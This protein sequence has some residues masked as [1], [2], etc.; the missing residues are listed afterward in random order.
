MSDTVCTISPNT[1]SPSSL[2]TV[3]FQILDKTFNIYF[4]SDDNTL[5]SGNTET[6]IACALLPSMKMG[7][8]EIRI[9]GEISSKFLSALDTIQDIYCTWQPSFKR[10]KITGITAL[11][12]TQTAQQKRVGAF[13][14][15]GVDSLY[16]F[17]KHN[18]EI[19]D[20]IFAYGLD[21]K[22]KDTVMREQTSKKIHA[23]ASEFGKNVIEIE[24]NLLELFD[25]YVNW[26]QLGHGA[27][28]AA[29]GHLFSCT[30]HR[31]Y[32]PSSY[33]YSNLFPWGS[34]PI[35]D[36]L[37]S[38]ENLEFI[39]D[40]CEA[41]RVN[42]VAL[43]AQYDIALNTL[44]VCWTNPDSVYNCGK[45]EKCIRTMINLKINNALSRCTTFSE[46][47][48]IKQVKKIVANTVGTRAFIQENL[49][50]LEKN[51]GDEK[52]R[53][54]LIYVLNKPEIPHLKRFRRK[55][56]NHIKEIWKR[57]F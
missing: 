25:F 37:W 44:R 34:H 3:D 23:I 29:I 48:D 17:L 54:A 6:F 50:A 27:A 16:T 18:E 28:L 42:K 43:I 55:I 46:E 4:K 9:N 47:L 32:I 49:D 40:G 33:S 56:K 36:P 39:H 21:I 26:G 2:I 20:V 15:G 52:L 45:C 24:T 8:G 5:I 41:T 1:I 53:K 12:R 19:T 13:F 11:Q 31:I 57:I 7:G 14:T 35:L 10:T 22:L 51:G 30:F 38:S